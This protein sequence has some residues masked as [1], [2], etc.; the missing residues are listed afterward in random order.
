MPS[1]DIVNEIDMQEADNAVN[2]TL[3]EIARRYD[4]KGSQTEI[5]LDKKGKTIHLVTGDDMKMTSLGDMLAEN[6]SKRKISP[7]V[8]EFGPTDSTSHGNIKRDVKLL[9]GIE[10]EQAK[11]IVKIIKDKKLKVQPAIQ[12][13]QVRVTGKKID[14]LQEV[15]QTLK[16]SD[17]PIPLQYVNMKS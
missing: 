6:F 16:G 5:T 12:G 1:F 9:D 13:N 15:I 7:R 14:D 4:F 11:K 10:K 2:N 3:K 8:L 17:L